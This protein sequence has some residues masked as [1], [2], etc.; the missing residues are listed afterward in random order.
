MQ[1]G[2]WKGM[3]QASIDGDASLVRYYLD[4]GMDPNFFHPE[5]M[6]NALLEAT[7]HGHI[8]VVEELLKRGALPRLKSQLGESAIQIAKNIKHKELLKKLKKA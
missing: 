3:I 4:Q 2:D 8:E 5:M 1:S 7:R 6:T